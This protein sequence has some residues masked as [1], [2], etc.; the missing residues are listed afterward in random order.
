M[1]VKSILL[2][3]GSNKRRAAGEQKAMHIFRLGGHE[4]KKNS[5]ECIPLKVCKILTPK[6]RIAMKSGEEVKIGIFKD[7][8][9]K[10]TKHGGGG[11]THSTRRPVINSYN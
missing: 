4:D 3:N 1:E 2:G 8:S 7:G 11:V 9:A 5:E 10:E 6:A